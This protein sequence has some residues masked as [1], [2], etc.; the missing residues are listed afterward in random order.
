MADALTL[1][2]TRP[3]GKEDDGPSRGTRLLLIADYDVITKELEKAR[4]ADRTPLPAQE[5]RR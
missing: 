3:G 4:L 5:I 1:L 2:L